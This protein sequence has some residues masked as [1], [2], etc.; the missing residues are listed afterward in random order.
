MLRQ[1]REQRLEQ[2]LRYALEKANATLHSYSETTNADGSPGHLVVE[3]SEH[4]H[5]YRYRT[6]I[7]QQNSN[8]TVVSS[9]ICLSGRDS[10]FDL[11]SLVNVMRH[12]D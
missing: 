6:L 2:G 10:D 5:T 1:Q 3:W 12:E 7:D 9:G 8:F 11:T 4:G